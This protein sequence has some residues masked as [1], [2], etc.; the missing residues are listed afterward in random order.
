M[1]DTSPV[2]PAVQLRVGAKPLSGEI[3][4]VDIVVDQQNVPHH[5]GLTLGLPHPLSHIFLSSHEPSPLLALTSFASLPQ[6]P[7]TYLP[8]SQLPAPT[9]RNVTRLALD[10]LRRG[11]WNPDNFANQVVQCSPT[12]QR[13]YFTL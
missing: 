13:H 6:Y 12:S 1:K 7:C 8:I 11:L 10:S 9:P 5:N 2:L 4:A 3:A